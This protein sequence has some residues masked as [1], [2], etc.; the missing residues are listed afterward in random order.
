[1]AVEPCTPVLK[2]S[3]QARGWFRSESSRR[4]M[5][6]KRSPTQNL[7]NVASHHVAPGVHQELLELDLQFCRVFHK[8][9]H[10][11]ENTPQEFP[12]GILRATALIKAFATIGHPLERNGRPDVDFR[13][14]RVTRCVE[15][16]HATILPHVISEDRARMMTDPS[17]G[18]PAM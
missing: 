17:S 9:R 16:H 7:Q 2:T 11:S 4:R 15:V 14:V 12:R 8:S 6:T 1:M 18:S 10:H 5:T 13:A 3:E